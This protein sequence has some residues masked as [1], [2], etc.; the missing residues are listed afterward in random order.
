MAATVSKGFLQSFKAALTDIDTVAMEPLGAI[1][2]TDNA[3]YKY[4]KFSG[5]T[6]HV[7]GDP[8]GYVLT[9]L[10]G[11]TVDGAS[12]TIGAGV[13]VAPVIASGTVQ[14]GWIQIGGVCT[15]NNVTAASAGLE[16]KMAATKTLVAKA[17]ATDPALGIN[18]TILAGASGPVFLIAPY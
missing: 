1:R 17:A 10:S 14:F 7:V 2:N 13:V 4:V 16:L 15:V 6:A 5:T 3:V 9:D 12:G 8:V 18:L 11:Q